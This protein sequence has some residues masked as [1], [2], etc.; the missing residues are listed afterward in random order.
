MT[1]FYSPSTG[2]FYA[3]EIHG[4]AV[5]ADAVE[6]S[7]KL[8]E[9]L[10]AAQAQGQVIVADADGKPV[11]RPRPAPTPAQSATLLSQALQAHVDG[12][13]RA[14]GYDSA[15]AAISYADEPSVPK[16]QA[17]ALAL[18][19]WRSQVWAAAEPLLAAV[20][21]GGAVPAAA[22]FITSLPKF[23]PPTP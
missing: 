17:E 1:K 21:G 16:Y 8:Y 6:I 10:F 12:A 22:D 5:P 3:S 9:G 7:D 19:A 14:L 23:T 18:R 15:V 11:A 20:A 13:A 4:K 2:G